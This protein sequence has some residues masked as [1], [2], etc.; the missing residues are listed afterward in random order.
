MR[1]KCFSVSS[2]AEATQR[3]TMA[4]SRQ[5]LTLWVRRRTPLCGP[6]S[7]GTHS[8]LGWQPR[9]PPLPS[10]TAHLSVS[11]SYTAQA[12]TACLLTGSPILLL[13][14]TEYCRW[15]DDSCVDSHLAPE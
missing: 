14:R 2:P 15:K 13:S 10:A 3:S 8:W 1:R 6:C 7:L 12:R 11:A 5:R 9:R 4:A